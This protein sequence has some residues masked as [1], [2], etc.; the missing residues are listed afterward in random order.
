MATTVEF[1]EY[2]CEQISGIVTE[3]PKPRKSN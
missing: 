3:L 1:I 2:V